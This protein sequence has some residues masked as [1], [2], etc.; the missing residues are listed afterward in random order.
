[1]TP[2][3]APDAEVRAPEEADVL[4]PADILRMRESVERSRPRPREYVMTRD[5]M[6]HAMYEHPRPVPG[7]DECRLAWAQAQVLS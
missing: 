2:T 3:E 4:T 1:M 5:G 6:R 7:C